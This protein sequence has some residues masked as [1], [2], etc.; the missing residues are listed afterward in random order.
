MTIV[1]LLL[2]LISYSSH[3]ETGVRDMTQVHWAAGTRVRLQQTVSGLPVELGDV[4]V[5]RDPWGVRVATYGRWLPELT[6]DTEPAVPSAQAEIS[7]R[8]VAQALGRGSLWQP[9]S[10]LVVWIDAE[11]RPLLAW[12]VDVS[13]ASPPQTFRV[14]VDAGSGEVLHSRPTSFSAEANVFV[15]NPETSSL[16]RVELAGLVSD[17]QLHGEYAT[18]W[19]C[20]DW[21]VDDSLFGATE[22]HELGQQ[23][24]PD[25]D[26]DYLYDFA[27]DSDPDPL[28]EVL[29]YFHTDRVSRWFFDRYGFALDRP[30]DTIVNFEMRN[31]FYGDF[32]GDG[33]ADLSF[34]HDPQTGI[35][36][37]YD[38]DVV[39]HEFGHAVVTETS[40]LG[41][42]SA[43]E[44][45]MDWAGGSLNEGSADGFALVLTG[46]PLMGEY[47]GSGSDDGHIR[48]LSAD[49]RCPDDLRGEVHADGE[50]W[51]ALMWNL[52][53]H[54]DVGEDVTADL[55]FGAVG[56]WV[57][58]QDWPKAGVSLLDTAG[59]M[60]AVGAIDGVSHDAIVAEVDAFNLVDC[61]RV[62]GLEPGQSRDLF[63]VNAGFAGD[64]ERMPLGVQFKT[65]I[66]E[67]VD[68]IRFEVSLPD[69]AEMGWGAYGRL[70]THVGHEVASL[71]VLGLA[72]AYPVDFDWSV[73]G[74]GTGALELSVGE[75]G[76]VIAGDEVYFSASSRTTVLTPFDFTIE[77]V[78]VAVSTGTD[79]EPER[80]GSCSCQTGASGPGLWGLTLMALLWR[81]RSTGG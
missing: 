32:D 57:P 45:G 26:G 80:S 17:E 49:R 22:C 15:G 67:G 12:A 1:S 64:F 75:Q 79:P 54:P 14:V 61:G 37:G 65:T 42:L 35:D 66:P 13:A 71:P 70:D 81:R 21:T 77:R 69:D 73:E 62:V 60:L 19:S 38:A 2:C 47:A 74:E 30:I 23:A 55:L 31:A 39:Y 50:I 51:G 41:T 10:E 78:Q 53:E 52:I 33:V 48:D 7:A 40:L 8:R 20:V 44:Y 34:G 3:A 36:F 28:A 63:M 43:D 58:N 5:A 25:V 29:V 4:V 72:G 11:D 9:K 18:A 27:P 68:W 59:E 6:V 76:D 24:T 46:D 16:E 56:T